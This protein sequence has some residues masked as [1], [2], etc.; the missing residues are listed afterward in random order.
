MGIGTSAALRSLDGYFDG[1][2]VKREL[3]R[4]LTALRGLAEIASGLVL[5]CTTLANSGRLAT[6]R[7]HFPRQPV[8]PARR[9]AAMD[10]A[11]DSA[12]SAAIISP[13]PPPAFSAT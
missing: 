9:N 6:V 8:S 10:N 7:P 13:P 3:N 1:F 2:Y 12:R 11:Y 4:D 5:K